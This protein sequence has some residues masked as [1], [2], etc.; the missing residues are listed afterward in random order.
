MREQLGL[1]C[2]VNSPPRVSIQVVPFSHGAHPGVDGS[3]T[4]ISYP[5]PV[6]LDVV[7]LEHMKSGA[8]VEE[9][10]RVRDYLMAFDHL[11]SVALSAPQSND[12]IRRIAREPD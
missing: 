12:L 4:V 7:L 6:D 11:R 9:P 3:F 2:E 5:D 10:E 1:L 8:Y